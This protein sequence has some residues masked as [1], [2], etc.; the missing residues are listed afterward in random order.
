MS[1]YAVQ[2][3]WARAHRTFEFDVRGEEA[4][5]SV[6]L[7]CQ[8]ARVG[9]DQVDERIERR[10]LDEVGPVADLHTHSQTDIHVVVG[11]PT[12]KFSPIVNLIEAL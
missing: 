3:K 2:V 5:D 9:V 12:L 11:V 6:E 8:C 10:T 7:C 4:E 1:S